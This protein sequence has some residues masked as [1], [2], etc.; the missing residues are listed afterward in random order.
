VQG[1]GDAYDPAPLL[2]LG[3]LRIAIRQLTLTAPV[4]TQTILD[5][6]LGLCP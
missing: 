1:E 6:A 4:H 5:Q 2:F 3:L